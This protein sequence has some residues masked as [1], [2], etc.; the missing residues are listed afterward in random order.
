M[1]LPVMSNRCATCPFNENGNMELRGVVTARLLK[2]SQLCHH[3][4]FKGVKETHVCRG[5]RDLQ[6][7]VMHRL[8]L[9]ETADDAG[10]NKAS[11]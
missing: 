9:L 1:M 7:A 5:A 8:G 11:E 6:I 10:W 4:R 2:S 3:P